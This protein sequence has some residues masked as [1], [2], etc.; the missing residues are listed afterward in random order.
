[1]RRLLWVAPVILALALD[2]PPAPACSL[3]TF[4]F[5]QARSFR[6][7]AAE[8]RVVL[9]GS[10]ENP[11]L[12]GTGGT[13]DLRLEAVLKSD[14]ILGDA[15]VVTLP[16][17][18]PVQDPKDPPR[19]LVFCDVFNDKLDPYR[20]VPTKAAAVEYLKGAMAL[21][22]KD[23]V[24]DLLYFARYLENP[25]R[26]IANDA[27]LEFAKGNDQE[28]GQAASKLQPEKLRGWLKD[29]QTPTNRLG[30]Y[31]LM[32]GAC[33]G[34]E[35][36]TLLRAMIQD[37]TDRTDVALDGLLA[38]YVRLRPKEGWDAVLGL[39]R[40]EKKPF[41]QR[42]GALRTL[43]FYHGSQPDET[44]KQV[45]QGMTALVG[46]GDIADLPVED[47]RRWQMWDLTGEVLAQYGK[48]SHGAPIMKRAL[49]RYAVSAAPHRPEAAA[50][51]AELRKT[52]PALLKEV[53]E[54]LQFEKKQ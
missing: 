43:R 34:D 48:K 6:Q 11:R 50:F 10:L 28:V 4:N 7:D 17:Y 30:L 51:V 8:A 41:L 46:Q 2:A 1:M 38:G 20:G 3:C 23:R 36:A 5:Q 44:K 49:V 29:A 27:F 52:D 37:S 19:F 53:E 25:D 12:Q 18:I 39:V 16:R 26:E 14:K 32:L 35:D 22:G 13:T 33:G 40:D 31:A 21:T 15:K 54:S 47:L 42:F 24:A 9:Y 45:L